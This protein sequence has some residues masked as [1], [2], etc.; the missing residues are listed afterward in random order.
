[1]KPTRVPK[2][3]GHGVDSGCRSEGRK[4]GSGRTAR[5]SRSAFL[6]E[7][8]SDQA[9]DGQLES[10]AVAARVAGEG[11]LSRFVYVSTKLI[12]VSRLGRRGRKDAH[13]LT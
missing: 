6:R 4:E 2:G 13:G 7:I 3:G 11:R 1:M 12:C 10:L 5:A 9:Y 8:E